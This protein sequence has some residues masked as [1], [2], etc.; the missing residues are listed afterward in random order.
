MMNKDGGRK[1]ANLLSIQVWETPL[2]L[3]PRKAIFLYQDPMVHKF[4]NY[5]R[6]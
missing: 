4:K 3:C 6:P 1:H 2:V 5:T